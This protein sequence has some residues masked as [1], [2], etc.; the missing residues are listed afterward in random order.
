MAKQQFTD[1][2]RLY[3]HVLKE[4]KNTLEVEVANEVKEILK[5]YLNRNFYEKY[6]I[7]PTNYLWDS[8]TVRA[9]KNGTKI[10]GLWI[11]FDALKIKHTSLFGSSSLSIK[12]GQKV[13]TPQWIND[14]WT[15]A[16]ADMQ[17]NFGRGAKGFARVRDIAEEPNFM[18][19]T[20]DALNS[21]APHIRKLVASLREKGLKIEV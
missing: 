16:P 21:T 20:I 5:K 19:D 1:L 13:Y 14:G 7:N 18:E 6:R 8:I 9:I 15:F 3:N 4:T 11:Y 12:K 10:V 17:T 2:G